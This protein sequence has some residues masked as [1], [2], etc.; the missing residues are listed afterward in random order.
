MAC[1]YMKC[2]RTIWPIYVMVNMQMINMGGEM[3][4]NTYFIDLFAVKESRFIMKK[5][6][7]DAPFNF[8]IPVIVSIHPQKF[9][10]QRKN[11]LRETTS[12]SIFNS[13]KGNMINETTYIKQLFWIHLCYL[14]H[15]PNLVY[16]R[17]FKV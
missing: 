17:F 15:P 1:P 13:I 9:K 11:S 14:F 5:G 4:F 16:L 3:R 8:M 2:N 12:T 7:L 10:G 6:A